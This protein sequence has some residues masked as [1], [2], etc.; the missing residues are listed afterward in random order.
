MVGIYPNRTLKQEG[1][2]R[3]KPRETPTDRHLTHSFWSWEIWKLDIE[4]ARRLYHRKLK[5]GSVPETER[6]HKGF[7][8]C[9]NN[10]A[11]NVNRF[12]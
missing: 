3:F 7:G 1:T 8:T 5:R 2:R 12:P 6:H 11:I 10:K 4:E 9:P